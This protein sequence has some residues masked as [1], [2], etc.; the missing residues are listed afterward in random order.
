MPGPFPANVSI[1]E[2]WNRIRRQT[3][4]FYNNKN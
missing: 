4:C 1:L 3:S 2:I